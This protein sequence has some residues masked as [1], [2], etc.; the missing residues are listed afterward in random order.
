MDNQHKM[1]K[2][3][4]VND[5]TRDLSAEE[6]ALMNEIKAMAEQVRELYNKVDLF[7]LKQWDCAYGVDGDEQE[8]ERL[9]NADPHQWVMLAK[10]D[11]Q[12]GFMKLTR[13]V[14]Q[15]TTF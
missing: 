2:G 14:A 1:I 15:P 5:A 8:C 10:N 4:S 13:A 6:I 11:L 12:T 9:S 7:V 3:L